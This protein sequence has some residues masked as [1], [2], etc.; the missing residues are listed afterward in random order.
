MLGLYKLTEK[1]LRLAFAIYLS[2]DYQLFSLPFQHS[3]KSL[4]PTQETVRLTLYTAFQPFVDVSR[5]R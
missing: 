4:A 2:C 5:T 1:E 3:N